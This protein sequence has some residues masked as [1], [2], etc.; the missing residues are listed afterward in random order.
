MI[1][2]PAQPV[3]QPG[4]KS[5]LWPPV[6]NLLLYPLLELDL[7]LD[8]DLDDRYFTLEVE[9]PIYQSQQPAGRQAEDCWKPCFGR[10]LGV[11]LEKNE[12]PRVNKIL[13]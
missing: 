9:S 5:S 6:E 8:L 7:D 4:Q 12:T 11:D 13:L 1:L 3:G 2:T 10:C